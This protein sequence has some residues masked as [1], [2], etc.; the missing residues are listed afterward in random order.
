MCVNKMTFLSVFFLTYIENGQDIVF[1]TA[2]SSIE[3]QDKNYNRS[4][5][6]FKPNSNLQTGG[7]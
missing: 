5:E 2:G 6:H 1:T 3:E 4:D 7:S